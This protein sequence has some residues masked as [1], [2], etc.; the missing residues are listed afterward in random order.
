M[1]L[2]TLLSSQS[3][4]RRWDEEMWKDSHEDI[5]GNKPYNLKIE[6]KKELEED[7]IALHTLL[8]LWD[9]NPSWYLARTLVF[10]AIHGF[11]GTGFTTVYQEGWCNVTTVDSYSECPK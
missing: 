10:E 4:E 11:L 7:L 9:P 3:K 2:Q 5:W 8:L 1:D 6:D